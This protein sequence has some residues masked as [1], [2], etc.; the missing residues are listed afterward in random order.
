MCALSAHRGVWPAGGGDLSVSPFLWSQVYLPQGVGSPPPLGGLEQSQ[1]S[2]PKPD[3]PADGRQ[4]AG[5]TVPPP[6]PAPTA[7]SLSPP[8]G[9]I[10]ADSQQTQEAP[11]LSACCRRLGCC[12]GTP[13]HGLGGLPS[14]P[15]LLRLTLESPQTQCSGWGRLSPQREEGEGQD[16]PAEPGRAPGSSQVAAACLPPLEVG[17]PPGDPR[18]M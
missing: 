8:P 6:T 10:C 7:S 4:R 3:P 5:R 1:S 11:V 14:S 15:G 18:I 13:A 9:T 16:Q 17:G 2:S 12:P